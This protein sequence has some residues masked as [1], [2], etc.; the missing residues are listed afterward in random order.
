MQPRQV[1]ERK[2]CVSLWFALSRPLNGLLSYLTPEQRK[3]YLI[4]I[5]QDGLYRWAHPH[6]KHVKCSGQQHPLVD[7]R[8]GEWVDTIGDGIVPRR[9]ASQRELDGHMQEADSPA[10][11]SVS[12]QSSQVPYPAAAGSNQDRPTKEAFIYVSD[13]HCERA[14]TRATW[15][16]SL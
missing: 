10:S 5:D 16:I 1:G 12:V 6:S 14:C 15:E 9:V 4:E 2:D 8:S 13:L 3:H 7:T 11:S